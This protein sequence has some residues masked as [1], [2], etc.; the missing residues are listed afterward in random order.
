MARQDEA[1]A[2][3]RPSRWIMVA[4]A[5]AGAVLVALL[6][7]LLGEFVRGLAHPAILIGFAVA[8]AVLGA[9]ASGIL[10]YEEHR[11]IDRLRPSA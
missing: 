10:A 9:Y 2:A 8:G 6:A 5:I 4:G 1:E 3:R 7:G 11:E